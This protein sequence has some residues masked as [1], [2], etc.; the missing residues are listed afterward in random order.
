VEPRVR[1]AAP[2]D[3]DGIARAHVEGWRVGYAHA[4]PADYLANMSVAA[5]RERWE[6]ALAGNVSDVF[7]AE[8]DGAVAGFVSC[9][10]SEDQD[11]QA[12]PGELYALYVEPS[13]WGKGLGRALLAR[14][15]Q[16]L[17]G[18]GF[19]EALL[20]VLEDNPRARRLY[21]A[22]GWAADGARKPRTRGGTTAA[23]VRYRKRLGRS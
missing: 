5:W 22:A 13:A 15:E 10:T 4:F 7:V 21:E 23:A 1:R 14:A 6:R 16:A 20:W 3:A 19:D 8:L 18:A 17:R 2:G 11:E 12:A 9:G